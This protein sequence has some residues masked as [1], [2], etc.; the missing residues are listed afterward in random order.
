MITHEFVLCSK[1]PDDIC[2]LDYAKKDMTIISDDFILDNHIPFRKVKMYCQYIGNEIDG[3]D[4]H[5]ITIITSDM[6]VKLRKELTD[7]CNHSKDL[8]ML[9]AILEESIATRGYVIHFGV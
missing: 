7:Y 1:V 4:Y 8:N 2:Y 5:G 6:A 3:L 9:L